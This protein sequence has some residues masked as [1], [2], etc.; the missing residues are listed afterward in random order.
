MG[1]E[2][3]GTDGSLYQSVDILEPTR[4]AL[5][6][7]SIGYGRGYVRVTIEHITA[8]FAGKALG[9]DGGEYDTVLFLDGEFEPGLGAPTEA[10]F[11]AA[12][13]KAVG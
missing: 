1:R 11:E 8:L 10:D 7:R 3:L 6:A 9:F 2:L 4:K 12:I 13:N 5:N